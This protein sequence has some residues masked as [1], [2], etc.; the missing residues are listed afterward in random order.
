MANFTSHAIMANILYNKLKD[1]DR[2]RVKIN[3]DKFKL[4]SYGQDLN[5][6]NFNFFHETHETKSKQFFMETIKYIYNHKLQYNSDVMA[7]L[8]GHIAHYA[9]DVCTHSFI[10]NA[11]NGVNKEG[12]LK[13]HTIIECDFDRYLINKYG[14]DHKYLKVKN[15][16]GV[17]ELVNSTYRSVYNEYNEYN[18][19]NTYVNSVRFIKL[20]NKPVLFS[21]KE[22]NIIELFT[23]RNKY[24][25]NGNF[26]NYLNIDGYLDEVFDKII[27]NSIRKSMII[28]SF[29][30]KYLY[31][32]AKDFYLNLVFDNTSYDATIKTDNEFGIDEIPVYSRLEIK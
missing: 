9:L 32:N 2:F 23:K 11:I 30:N 26:Y 10:V 14:Y 31:R 7:Y 4:F 3:K 28:I 18:N 1:S 15:L 29:V 21:Y 13:P 22:K 25:N 12:F 16:K 5:F 6:V 27:N 17:K 8:Y 19:Y 24:S 20:C